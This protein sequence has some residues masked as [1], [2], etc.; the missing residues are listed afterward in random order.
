M[1]AEGAC[2]W[3]AGDG[4]RGEGENTGCS[5]FSLPLLLVPRHG[6]SEMLLIFDMA[7]RV[8]EERAIQGEGGKREILT[9]RFC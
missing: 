7:A 5:V 8:L 4:C 9:V 3:E 1:A 2:E 6:G